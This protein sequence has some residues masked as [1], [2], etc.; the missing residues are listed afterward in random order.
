MPSAMTRLLINFCSPRDPVPEVDKSYRLV[1]QPMKLQV[2]P[3]RDYFVVAW[4]N[5]DSPHSLFG[6]SKMIIF[7]Q[8]QSIHV[9]WVILFIIFPIVEDNEYILAATCTRNYFAYKS[10]ATQLLGSSSVSPG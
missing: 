2:Y 8:Y 3:N 7:H 4:M 1:L 9:K 5:L 6:C 10:N